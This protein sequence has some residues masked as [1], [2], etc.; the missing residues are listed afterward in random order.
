MVSR[1]REGV[2][3]A[4][5]PARPR[6]VGDEQ[7]TIRD[8]NPGRVI[9]VGLRGNN[10]TAGQPPP[11]QTG[12]PG[13]AGDGVTVGQQ[14]RSVDRRLPRPPWPPPRRARHRPVCHERADRRPLPR[15]TPSLSAPPASPA[16]PGRAP[17]P[18]GRATAG[19]PS[20]APLWLNSQGPDRNGAAAAC[21]PGIPTVADRTA[22]SIA[23][24]RTTRARSANV[25]SD[26]I[27]L[28]PRCR[29]GS[30]RPSTYQPIPN[31]S[32]LTTPCCAP[33]RPGLADK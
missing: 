4:G 28:A 9:V 7:R 10:D 12:A 22:A 3:A 5:R 25:S 6:R 23:A 18:T 29:A 32:A 19:Q 13:G 1:F 24:V 26:H 16:R 27:G 15:A 14:D 8:V 21:P 33:R 2:R 31:P 30:T 11:A 17:S 20:T